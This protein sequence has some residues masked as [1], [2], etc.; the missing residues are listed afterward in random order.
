MARPKVHHEKRV[1]TA[2]RIPESLHDRLREAADERDVSVNLLA[3]RALS[4]FLDSLISPEELWAAEYR[5]DA[6][7]AS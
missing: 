1:S 3:T 6:A 4:E 5:R 2:I 7:K